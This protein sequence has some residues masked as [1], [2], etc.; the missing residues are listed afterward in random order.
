M[1]NLV[2]KLNKALKDKKH[3]TLVISGKDIILRA[4]EK[5]ELSQMSNS[6]WIKLTYDSKE[7][8]YLA[9]NLIEQVKV[10]C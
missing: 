8:H 5:I 7:E 9:F 3:V 1:D 10:T 4:D 6:D 2:D